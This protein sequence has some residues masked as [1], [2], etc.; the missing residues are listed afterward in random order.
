MNIPVRVRVAKNGSALNLN[1]TLSSESGDAHGPF[2]PHGARLKS[3]GSMTW[4]GASFT[5]VF[6]IAVHVLLVISGTVQPL[7]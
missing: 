6:G 3:D 5:S 7:P 4:A 2:A 1:T